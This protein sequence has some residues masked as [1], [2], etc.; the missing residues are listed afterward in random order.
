MPP[1]STPA[2]KQSFND[3]FNAARKDPTS[4]APR[5]PPQQPLP[6][7]VTSDGSNAA[8]RPMNLKVG[9]TVTTTP[10]IVI[11]KSLLDQQELLQR[12]KIGNV[13]DAQGLQQGMANA[14]VEAVKS[15]NEALAERARL[16]AEADAAQSKAQHESY[17]AIQNQIAEL[18]NRKID[19]N[20]YWKDIGPGGTALA[21]IGTA[22]ST[23]R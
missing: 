14:Q 7:E 5:L 4:T 17:N 21:L 2:P 13:D 22:L 3:S 23:F 8:N 19:P 10:G 1:V 16:D 18:G 11:P 6:G 9:E 15:R 20:K 12:Q